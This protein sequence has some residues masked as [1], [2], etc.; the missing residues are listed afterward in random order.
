[1]KVNDKPKQKWN[2]S[3]L[4]LFSLSHCKKVKKK[5]ESILKFLSRL[6]YTM[7]TFTW[8]AFSLYNLSFSFNNMQFNI[9][10]LSYKNFHTCLMTI[11]PW[12]HLTIQKSFIMISE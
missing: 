12:N 9:A 6:D 1:M 7:F 11:E 4:K 2:K 5:L 3:S 8:A 10:I